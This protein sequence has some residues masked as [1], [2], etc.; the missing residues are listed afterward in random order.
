MTRHRQSDS[1]I[2]ARIPQARARARR[3]LIAEPH[4]KAARFDK[5]RRTLQVVLTNGAAL[6]IPV[7]LVYALP[8]ASEKDLS[9]VSVGPAG[10]GLR[11]ETLDAD[12]SVSH[13]ADVALG[14]AILLRAAGAAGGAA[15][16]RAKARAAQANG[17]KGGRPRRVV[18]SGS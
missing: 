11:W 18:R 8:A 16:T 9:E 4:A 17:K 14:R 7:H 6:T 12:L 15:R 10:V 1:E 3:A 13:L 5:V 2:L